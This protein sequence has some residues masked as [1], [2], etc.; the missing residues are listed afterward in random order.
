[1]ELEQ[2]LEYVSL[3]I[4]VLCVIGV[5][6]IATLGKKKTQSREL[7]FAACCIALSFVLSFV[8]AK[9]GAEGGSVDR[10]SVV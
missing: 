7:V 2:I 6:L 10:K 4:V 3:G 8:K 5:L 9:V 1:M